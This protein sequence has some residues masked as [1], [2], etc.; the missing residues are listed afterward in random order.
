MEKMW[1]S[2]FALAPEPGWRRSSVGGKGSRQGQREDGWGEVGGETAHLPLQSS[3][4]N[5]LPSPSNSLQ[6][7]SVDPGSRPPT[8]AALPS[9]SQSVVRLF[10]R[11]LVQEEFCFWAS[12]L[13]AA[14][15]AFRKRGG[16]GRGEGGTRRFFCGCFGNLPQVSVL[17]RR[18]ISSSLPEFPRLTSS[19]SSP[20][21][22]I[23]ADC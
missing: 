18:R 14:G 5:I 22:L 17:L 4:W 3:D 6:L 15:N 7:P 21:R 2:S 13:S 8:A 16:G 19:C 9:V 1:E 10:D 20:L 11:S 23:S 12:S